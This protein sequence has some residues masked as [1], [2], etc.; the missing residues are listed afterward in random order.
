MKVEGGEEREVLWVPAQEYESGN[1][2]LRQL[3]LKYGSLSD[4]INTTTAEGQ[5]VFHI[6]H[7]Y[8]TSIIQQHIL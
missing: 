4:G 8:K 7:R 2:A 5:L 3:G 6:S 1:I